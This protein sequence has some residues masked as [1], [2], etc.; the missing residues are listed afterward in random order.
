MDKDISSRGKDPQLPALL[1]RTTSPVSGGTSTPTPL[2]A[3][4]SL[5]AKSFEMLCSV[6][7]PQRE[8]SCFL[9]RRL[10][11]PHIIPTVGSAQQGRASVLLLRCCPTLRPRCPRHVLPEISHFSM[12]TTSLA[13]LLQ[14]AFAKALSVPK[15][16]I[17]D[18]MMM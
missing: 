15:P 10:F 11:F 5:G 17:K 9:A 7:F 12:T 8:G 13:P 18:D 2:E 16:T 4:R 3:L 1:P 6:L 14:R